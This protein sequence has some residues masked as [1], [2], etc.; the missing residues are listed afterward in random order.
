[1]AVLVCDAR[2][3]ALVAALVAAQRGVAAA[4]CRYEFE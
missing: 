2:I 3:A 4:E 1:M